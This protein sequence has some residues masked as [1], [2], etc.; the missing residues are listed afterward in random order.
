MR[1]SLLF[2]LLLASLRLSAQRIPQVSIEEVI[3]RAQH[4]SAPLVVVNFWATFC[5]PCVEEIPDFIRLCGTDTTK[6]RLLLVSLD[7][8]DTYPRQLQAFIRK[9]KWNAEV[10]WLNDSRAD[11]F[12]PRIDPSWSGS[13]P[14]T[15]FLRPRDGQSHFVEDQITAEQLEQWIRRG[16]LPPI[17]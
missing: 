5:K 13:I 9:R 17:N 1:I 6:I 10:L 16:G 12:C 14:A 3:S 4:A 15:L 7:P 11:Y 2:L 8:P